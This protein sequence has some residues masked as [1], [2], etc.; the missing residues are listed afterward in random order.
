MGKGARSKKPTKKFVKRYALADTTSH[1]VDPKLVEKYRITRQADKK[2][3]LY[4]E[5]RTQNKDAK[6]ARREGREKERKVLKDK[7]PA[8]LI[9]KTKE[10]L[11]KPDETFV[12]PIEDDHEI[13]KD[14]ADDEFAAFFKNRKNPRILITTGQRPSYKTKV[15]VKEAKW[16]FP[17]CLYR[18][19]KDY[20]LQEITQ[21][22][23]NRKFTDLIVITERLKQPFNMIVSHLPEGP[24]ATFRI[25]NFLSNKE[26]N[27]T[28]ERTEHYPELI[29]KNFDTRLGRRIGRMLECLFPST[30]DYAGR[31]VATFHNQR[32]YIFLRVHRY[33]FDSMTAVRIQEMG[34]R[35]TLRLLSL[36]SGTFDTQFG[37]YE[38]FRKKV[39]DD[40]KLE[41]YM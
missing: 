19:R 24:T 3:A 33:I 17:N 27:N 10:R 25:S 37:E 12:D 2:R 41:W 28:A 6:R 21:F 16:L 35:F 39:H 8:K 38:W 31:A 34:P 40:D 26:L 22:C 13:V 18:P 14:E 15:F 30:R 5:L 29:F 32:D 36:Q 4:N 9:P 7:A 23:L 20:T 1:E 11:R